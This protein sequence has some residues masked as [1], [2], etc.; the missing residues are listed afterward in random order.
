MLA[1]IL[2]QRWCKL[3]K[4]SNV[5]VVFLFL[6][7][8]CPEIMST[9]KR[10]SSTSLSNCST[11]PWLTTEEILMY[12]CIYP[13]LFLFYGLQYTFIKVHH[14]LFPQPLAPKTYYNNISSYNNTSIDESCFMSLHNKCTFSYVFAFYVKQERE[15]C[16]LL[17]FPA[18][19]EYAC[20]IVSVG[21]LRY[22]V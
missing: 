21:K 18:Y 6:C 3:C 16:C 7:Y 11:I 9:I 17:N 2:F 19:Y 14:T 22:I 10:N 1:F 5:N 4:I 20:S 12:V 15:L 8:F 13:I